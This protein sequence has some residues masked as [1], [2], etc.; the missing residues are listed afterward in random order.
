LTE[1]F[2][3]TGLLQQFEDLPRYWRSGNEAEVDF[4]VQYKNTIIPIEVK[5]DENVKAKS[6]AFYRKRYTPPLSIRYS[7]RNLKKDGGFINI[8]LFMVDYTKKIIELA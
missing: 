4:L 2:I 1:N 3:L 8:P 7:M 5:A 6:L